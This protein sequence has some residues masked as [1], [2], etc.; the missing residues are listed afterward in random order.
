M[1]EPRFSTSTK[2][3]AAVFLRQLFHRLREDGDVGLRVFNGDPLRSERSGD[4]KC[5]GN[6]LG[7]SLPHAGMPPPG[8]AG[9]KSLVAVVVLACALHGVQAA[10]AVVGGPSV[11]GVVTDSQSAK[12][13]A[14][15]QAA[16]PEGRAIAAE[17][18]PEIERAER[19]GLPLLKRVLIIDL[20]LFIAD[21]PSA[22]DGEMYEPV[23]PAV[24]PAP[25]IRTPPAPR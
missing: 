8:K 20:A 5:C 24:P 18:K 10:G 12:P 13:V 21:L 19:R 7:L 25:A 3:F 9:R 23:R 14:G 15:A 11:Q 22:R 17:E 4:D 1:A 2:G 6:Q 16:T